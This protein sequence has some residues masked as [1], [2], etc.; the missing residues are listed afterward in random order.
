MKTRE[1]PSLFIFSFAF[2][3]AALI[4]APMAPTVWADS[5]KGMWGRVMPIA[6]GG[7]PNLYYN[8]SEV[9]ELRDM[10]LTKKSPQ[11]LVDLYN[12]KIKPVMAARTC[13]TCRPDRTNMMAA[14]S[15]MIE[16]TAAKADAIRASLLSYV[17]LFPKGAGTW[18]QSP[19]WYFSGYA[20]PWM[21]D[22]ILAY[23]PEKLTSTDRANLKA[24]FKMTAWRLIPDKSWRKS[25]RSNTTSSY[26][27]QTMTRW[28][29]WW[30]RYLGPSLA[31]ALMSGDQAAVDFW[32]DSGWPHNQFTMEGVTYAGDPNPFP[33]ENANQHD[34][35]MYLLTVYPS[36][37]NSDSYFREGYRHSDR[38]WYT[39]SYEATDTHHD[40]GGDYH[41]AQQYGAVLAAEMAYH[42]GMTQV[43]A[44]KG[45]GIEPALLRSHKK[46][47]DSRTEHDRRPTSLTGHPDIGYDPII[48]LGYRRYADSK[49]EGAVSTL[50]LSAGHGPESFNEVFT[51]MGYP[52]RTVWPIGTSPAPAP[53]PAPAPSPSP[54]PD[55][56]APSVT[57]LAPANGAVVKRSL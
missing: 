56:T 50:R 45:T 54:T 55:A 53:A 8:Q 18:Y 34:L 49:I 25:A 6:D 39:H 35:V 40:D 41:W 42:N 22:L 29:N 32:A 37:A 13:D 9:L 36:G 10:I 3:I 1:T 31:A 24:W 52:R 15:Y 19:G 16:P 23:H 11:S 28:E 33:S 30:S 48:W 2:F 38:T 17:A 5:P 20:V 21:Y 44:I 43:F 7:H 27:G 57:I 12:T 14:L 4:S 46:A 26:E 51:F 47:I